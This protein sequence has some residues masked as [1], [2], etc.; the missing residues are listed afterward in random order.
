MPL[1]ESTSDPDFPGTGG[2]SSPQQ[3]GL[4][5]QDPGLQEPRQLAFPASAADPRGPTQV[6]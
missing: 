4:H 2:P 6:P 3:E 1:S 5:P